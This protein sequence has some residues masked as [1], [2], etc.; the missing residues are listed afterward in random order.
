MHLMPISDFTVNLAT[1]GFGIFEG[2]SSPSMIL[3]TS[4]DTPLP[5]GEISLADAS[6]V[7]SLH[8]LGCLFGNII[9]GW[10]IN[11]FGRRLPLILL[12]FPLAVSIDDEWEIH[13]SERIREFFLKNH[14]LFA[15]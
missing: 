15:N 10:I 14:H 1:I 3:L 12:A 6:W 13:F 4:V 11:K 8:G 9:F 5:S 7:A 2:W